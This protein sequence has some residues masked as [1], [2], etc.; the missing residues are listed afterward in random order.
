MASNRVW[1]LMYEAG[2]TGRVFSASSNPQSRAS[3]ISSAEQLAVNRWHVWVEHVETKRRIFDRP[4]PRPTTQNG[5][6]R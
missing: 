5:G 3:A 4:S 1:N 6:A 2:N